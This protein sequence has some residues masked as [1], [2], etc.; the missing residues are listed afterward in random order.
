[1][2]ENGHHWGVHMDVRDDDCHVCDLIR[3]DPGK[4]STRLRRSK[5]AACD[6]LASLIVA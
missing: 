2:I 4:D 3:R 1:M 6:F 5:V